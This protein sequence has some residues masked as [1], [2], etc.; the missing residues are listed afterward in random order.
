MRV[1]CFWMSREPCGV[2]LEE[3]RGWGKGITQAERKESTELV[4]KWER[5]PPLE[6][7][8]LMERNGGLHLRC[9]TVLIYSAGHREELRPGYVQGHWNF[10]HRIAL[11]DAYFLNPRMSEPQ[12]TI[13]DQKRTFKKICIC[14]CPKCLQQFKFNA[15]L[16]SHLL[17]WL[18]FL[19]GGC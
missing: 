12:F 5:D 6:S 14:F 13:I 2:C 18:K 1:K 19:R 3:W 10:L 15:H 8:L 11:V 7:L 4:G 9:G 16:F 17:K